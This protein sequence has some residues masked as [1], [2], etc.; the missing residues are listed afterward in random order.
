[1]DTDPALVWERLVASNTA[2][3]RRGSPGYPSASST[4]GLRPRSLFA[5]GSIAQLDGPCV[6][7]VGHEISD[8]LRVCCRGRAR[9]GPVRCRC[10]RRFRPGCRHRRRGP[11]G[12]ARARTP[13]STRSPSSVGESTWSIPR[14]AAG[15]GRVLEVSGGI[16]SEAA[17]GPHPKG[18]AFLFATGS[19]AALAHVVVVVE[20][21]KAGGALHTVTAADERGVTVLAVPGSVRSSASEGTNS[22]IADGC[23]VAR[24]AADVLAALELARAGGNSRSWSARRAIQADGHRPGAASRRVPAGLSPDERSVLEALEDVATPFERRVQSLRPGARRDGCHPRAP[25]D[26][27][28]GCTIRF[29]LGAACH[30]GG[31]RPVTSRRACLAGVSLWSE[32]PASAGH[33][34]H[35]V[36]PVEVEGGG[37]RC[38]RAVPRTVLIPPRSTGSAAAAASTP[39]SAS[40]TRYGKV[41]LVRA[42]VEVCGTAAGMF[43]TA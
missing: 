20:S 27:R 11:R 14:A 9:G 4:T 36:D 40:S 39:C 1:M 23:G 2:A 13:C 5:R 6:A 37:H 35:R 30:S 38:V 33:Q 22:L 31:A 32:A 10:G 12:G 18:G 43:P 42:Y 25:C 19:I 28:L 16:L 34:T 15:S 29:R 17:P 41:A 3:Y 24:D 21:H 26:A 7:L 8:A